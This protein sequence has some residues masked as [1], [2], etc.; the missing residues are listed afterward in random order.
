LGQRLLEAI[1]SEARRAGLAELRLEVRTDNVAALQ[2][3]QRNG[4]QR[5]AERSGYYEDGC[6]AL[7]LR[8]ILG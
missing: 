1:E 2:L 4:Y 8:K 3:Y 5:F 7:R 6:N